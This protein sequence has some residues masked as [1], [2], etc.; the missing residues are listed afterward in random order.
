MF[1]LISTVHVILKSLLITGVNT[2]I[3]LGLISIGGFGRVF[4]GEHEGQMVAL[5]VVDR[6]R[7]DVCRLSFSFSPYSYSP[8]DSLKRDLCQ[9]VL[10]WRSL[11][12]RFILPLL[13]IYEEK[14]QLFLVSQFM[15]NGTLTQWRKKQKGDVSEVR[16]L[17]RAL[18][19]S[20]E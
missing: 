11:V 6:G 10:A 14:S 7:N 18:Y 5:K 2:E 9:E 16:R 1:R 8:K 17:V 13:G 12:H 20:E 4:K 15:I 3:H 19:F